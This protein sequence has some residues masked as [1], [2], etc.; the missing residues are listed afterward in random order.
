MSSASPKSI[1]SNRNF[2]NAI[3]ALQLG[4]LDDAER[5]FN[6]VLHAEPK[7]IGALNLMG[8]VL[9]QQKRFAEAENYFRRALHQ[10]PRSDAILYNYGIVLKALKRPAEA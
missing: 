2:Q 5:L 4:R 7:H 10:N 3:A 6:A 1:A 8:A 9:T